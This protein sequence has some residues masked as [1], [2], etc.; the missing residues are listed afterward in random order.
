M[1]VRRL[2]PWM[3][4]AL[5]IGVACCAGAAIWYAIT[6]PKMPRVAP[7]LDIRL[8]AA[9]ARLRRPQTVSPTEEH[10]RPDGEIV[11]LTQ[12]QFRAANAAATLPQP[13]YD[14]KLA[15]AL[16]EENPEKRVEQLAAIMDS[17]PRDASGDVTAL[18]LYA[19]VSGALHQ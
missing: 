12:D 11:Y 18:G 15:A 9:G 7:A 1:A 8:Q 5:V 3:T 6:A 4:I 13:G 17:V 19:L 16:A 2:R 14:R 10:P